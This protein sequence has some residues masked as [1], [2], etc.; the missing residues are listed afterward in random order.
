MWYSQMWL[1]WLNFTCIEK[2]HWLPRRI[3]N[4]LTVDLSHNGKFFDQQKNVQLLHRIAK[5]VYSLANS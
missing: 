1:R 2:W 4:A 3:C 5:T